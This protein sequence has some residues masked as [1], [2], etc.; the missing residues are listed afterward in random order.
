MLRFAMQNPHAHCEAL[1][2]ATDRDRYLAGLFAPAA[3]RRHLYALYA[4]ASEIA[5]VRE[6]AHEPLPGE[7]RLQWWRDALSGKGR[8]EALANPIAAAFLDTVAQ[9]ALP[10]EPLIALIDAHAFDL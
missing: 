2:R 10:K 5:R 8:G 3:A 1:V 9:C 7:I 6:A 4:F